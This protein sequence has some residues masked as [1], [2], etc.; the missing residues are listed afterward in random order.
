MEQEQPIISATSPLHLSKKRFALVKQVALDIFQ[1]NT[2]V[3]QFITQFCAIM[4]F[5]PE[6]GIYTPEQG[7]VMVE[8]V[9]Q[10]ATSLGVSTY[11]ASGAKNYYHRNK[12]A[13]KQ[14]RAEKYRMNKEQAC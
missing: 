6:I 2:L 10:K 11:E 14:R 12:E 9:R 3:D 8:K 7:K 13:I 4:K 5:N 1:D